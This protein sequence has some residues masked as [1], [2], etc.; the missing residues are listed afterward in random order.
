MAAHW[1]RHG[2]G[3]ADRARLAINGMGAV[4]TGIA[5]AIILLAK[6]TEGAW[7]TVL[8]I[9]ATLLLLRLAHRYYAALD[10]QLLHGHDAPLDLSR[11][12]PPHLLIPIGRWDRVARRRVTFAMRLSRD[13]TA[14]HCTELEGPDAEEHEKAIRERLG[15]PASTAPPPMPACPRPRCWCAPRPTAACSARC[16]A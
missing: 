6:F 5:L 8:V 13:V 15:A 2:R 14:L 11:P 12:R 16:C 1:L 10:R 3:K 9:P 7:L 4:A